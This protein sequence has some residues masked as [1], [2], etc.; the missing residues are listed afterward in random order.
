MKTLNLTG[1]TI[2]NFI[3]GKRV[4]SSKYGAS[5]WLVKC[6]LCG[7][8]T[9]RSGAYLKSDNSKSVCRGHNAIDKNHPEYSLFQ[10][11]HRRAV[12]VGQPGVCSDWELTPNGFTKFT[13]SMGKQPEGMVLDR[14]D[15]RL[16]YS[17]DNCRWEDPK[18]I[19]GRR[20]SNIFLKN[21]NGVVK[22]A[23]AWA[24]T[25]GLTS[26]TFKYQ[27]EKGK[28]PKLTLATY[29]EFLDFEKGM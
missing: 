23:A 10:S 1:T 15:S 28:F 2:Q 8:E 27:F 4:E 11:M 22:I 20:S 18:T 17:P 7:I 3:V 14:V 29:D 6:K 12:L 16:G 26:H 9:I 13:K 25:L 19:S 5:R 24:M 21:S